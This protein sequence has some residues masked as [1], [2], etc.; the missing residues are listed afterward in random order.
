MRL[1]KASWN[2][3]SFS[4]QDIR[5]DGSIVL[6]RWFERCLESSSALDTALLQ[7]AIPDPGDRKRILAVLLDRTLARVEGL[8][9]PQ[10]LLDARVVDETLP[11]LA[12]FDEVQRSL[13]GKAVLDSV[14]LLD[15]PGY[16]SFMDEHF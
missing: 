16:F 15:L 2:G 5:Q 13:P 11:L 8:H 1:G 12:A 14:D 3:L 9:L 6:W 7:D 4:H 10:N